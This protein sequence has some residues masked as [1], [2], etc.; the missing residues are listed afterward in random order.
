[1]PK[2]FTNKSTKTPFG[3]L[4]IERISLHVEVVK[5]SVIEKAGYTENP[6]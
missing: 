4:F 5:T 3:D 1:M 6:R 2:H